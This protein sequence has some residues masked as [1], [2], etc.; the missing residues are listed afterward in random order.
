MCEVIDGCG[1]VIENTVLARILWLSS[2]VLADS[3]VQ[4][5]ISLGFWPHMSG[6][7]C[8]VHLGMKR[9]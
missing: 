6:W 5:M 7:S 4:V 1:L 2:K 8:S 9:W 3:G